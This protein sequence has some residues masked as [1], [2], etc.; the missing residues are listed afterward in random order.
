MCFVSS[1][2]STYNIGEIGISNCP[3]PE[4]I[5]ANNCQDC[6]PNPTR[7]T[8]RKHPKINYGKLSIKHNKL[9][10]SLAS[11]DVEILHG[12]YRQSEEVF[13]VQTSEETK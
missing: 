12:N 9:Y 7:I 8:Q 4:F 3:D 10:N 2:H 13:R 1:Y 5:P 11:Y 6:Q